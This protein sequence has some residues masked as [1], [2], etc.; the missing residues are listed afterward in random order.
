MANLPVLDALGSTKYLKESGA[1]TDVDPHVG[2]TSVA[3]GGIAS[4]AVASGAIA[5][6]AMVAG[7]QA[8]GHSSTLG[9]TTTAA[10]ATNVVEDTTA[11]TG[12]GLFKGIKNL[13][14]LINDKLVTG[15]DIGDVTINNATDAGVY[16]RP[17][18]SAE[19]A[20]S[21]A[22]GKVAS[23]AIA[24]GAVASGAIASGAVAAGAIAAGAVVSGAILSGALATG[25]ITD[26]P[27]KGQALMAASMPVAIASDQTAVPTKGGGLSVT[28]TL[29]VTNGAYTTQDVVGGLITFANAVSAN[30][31]ECVLNSLELVGTTSAIAF[32]LW[33]FNADLATP[34]ADNAAFA[35]VAADQP[36]ILGIVPISSADFYQAGVGGVYA[37]SVPGIGRQMKAGAATTSLL[38]YMKHTTTTSP[39]TTSLFLTCNFEYVS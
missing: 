26:L 25:A 33:F 30:G 6:G 9:L 28:A 5:S 4:G 17:G 35:I 12:I 22:S 38:A 13:L 29:T 23:G 15:T 32:E 7:S 24:S 1:G 19:F 39:G 2:C 16:V 34:L 3:S 37:A 18:T 36:K 20:T 11:K 8:D 14:K 31:K 21:L 27:V 10:A